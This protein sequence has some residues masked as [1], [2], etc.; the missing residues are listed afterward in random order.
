[1]TEH[2]LPQ[3]SLDR[4]FLQARTFH[5]WQDTA[6]SDDTLKQLYELMR[7]APTSMNCN[8][9]R[10][11]F[12]RTAQAKERLYPA[13]D[14]GNIRK[15][16]GAPV[17]AIVAYDRRFHDQLPTL[18]PHIDAR[19]KFVGNEPLIED[20]AFRNG[21]LQG[22]Y[23]I[24]AARALGLDCGP[25]SGF[26]NDQV[27]RIFFAEH[28]RHL[29]SNFLC[30]LGYGDADQVKPRGTRLDFDTACRLL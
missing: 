26:D 12:L 28:D 13:L 9:A 30:N 18:F 15:V 14:E 7:W 16:E 4:L 21:T 19:A 1:M 29:R 3:A 2:A 24:L 10:I 5:Y 6:V 11:Y 17:T 22:G 8:P 27:D 20:T 25:L 23:M